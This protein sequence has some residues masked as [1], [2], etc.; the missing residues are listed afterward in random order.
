MRQQTVEA[1][2][3]V[4]GDDVFGDFAFELIVL[5]AIERYDLL[6][7]PVET[8]A[9]FKQVAYVAHKRVI[10]RCGP[11]DGSI[12][13][14]K[15]EKSQRGFSF[16]DT[17]IQDHGRYCEFALQL[18]LEHTDA[19]IRMQRFKVGDEQR[20]LRPAAQRFKLRFQFRL[21]IAR[22]Q[23]VF[24]RLVD[25]RHCLTVT[26]GVRSARK[27]DVAQFIRP[28]NLQHRQP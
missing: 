1:S 16:A 9:H 20:R 23:R 12:R 13:Q 18:L 17:G 24:Q 19:Q 15:A 27:P 8:A 14:V 3:D 25:L 5:R 11:N 10:R 22:R 7:P 28:K 26:I 21:M 2:G 6:D 4:V